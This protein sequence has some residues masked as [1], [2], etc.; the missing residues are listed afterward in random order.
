[1][2][3]FGI[4]GAGNIAHTFCRAIEATRGQLEGIASRDYQKALL[5]Q[6]QYGIPHAYGSYQALYNNPN[7]DCVYVATPHGLHYEQMMEILDYGK[8][9]L[10]EKAFTLN[11]SQAKKVFE[12]ARDKG[13][14]VMEAMWTRFLPN[15]KHL[16]NIIKDGVIG[17]ITRLEADFC[18]NAKIDPTHRLVNPSLG[19][20]ALLDIGIYPITFANIFLRTP[21]KIESQVEWYK[22]QVDISE[23]L[24]YHYPNAKAI[25]RSSFN[26]ELPIDAR[27]YGTK[28]FIHVPNFWSS[29]ES[30]IYDSNHALIESVSFKHQVNGFEYE[31]DE[32]IQMIEQNNLESPIMPHSETL[33]ILK[34]MDSIRNAW[35]FEYPQEKRK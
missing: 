33:T 26:S 28:G 1:M 24:T 32:T 34:Q 10:C 14:F 31:I 18:F 5:Y 29:E 30:H 12:K 8:H 20:G 7:I 22:S 2:V 17:E 15:V 3:K 25:L 35:H 13:C 6:K 23:T 4:I 21:D 9:I 11:A 19:G 16:Q 27:I